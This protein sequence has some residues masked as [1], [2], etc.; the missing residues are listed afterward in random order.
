VKPGMKLKFD[1]FAER[2]GSPIDVA[3]VL[4]GEKGE[5]LVRVEDGP[6]TLDPTLD[7]VV[8]D[9]ITNLIVGVVDAQGRGGPHGIYRLAISSPAMA[10][11]DFALSTSLAR[12]PVPAKGRV[13]LPIQAERRGYKGSIAIAGADL[14]AGVELHGATIPEDADGVLLTVQRQSGDAGAA[15]IA[16]WVGKSTTG[17]ERTV[18]VKGHPLE[19]LQPWLAAEISVSAAVRPDEFEIDWTKPPVEVVLGEKLPLSV[20]WTTPGK[21]PLDPAKTLRLEKVVDAPAMKGEGDLVLIVPVELPSPVYD[22]TVVA[23]ALAADKK[24]VQATAYAPV[25]RLAVVRPIRIA[26]KDSPRIEVVSDAKKGTSVSIAG[27]VERR[28]G[29]QGIATVT[30]AGLPAAIKAAPVTVPADKSEFALTIALPPA[31][32]VGEIGGLK[33]SAAIATDPKTPMVR[34]KSADIDVTLVVQSK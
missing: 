9:K 17:E 33:L 11:S 26:L 5:V 18:F 22:V 34:V 14:P 16:R 10:G 23:E 29:T 12:L 2:I 7:Y 8:P 13:V 28:E 25:R 1:V 24:T 27:K 4:R 21:A 19:R 30:L 31:T 20:K 6:K 32:P 15:A 3:L